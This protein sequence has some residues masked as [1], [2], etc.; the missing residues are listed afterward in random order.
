MALVRGHRHSFILGAK[1]HPPWAQA[2]DTCAHDMNLLLVPAHGAPA[3]DPSPR[4][5]PVGVLISGLWKALRWSRLEGSP[6]QA[7]GAWQGGPPRTGWR[8][9]QMC[10]GRVSEQ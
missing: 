6:G 1:L 7:A 9:C 2:G 3:G 8:G 10:A 4:S 5:S